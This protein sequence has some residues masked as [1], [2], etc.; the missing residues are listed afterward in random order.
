MACVHLAQPILQPS[1]ALPH[2]GSSFSL[3]SSPALGNNQILECNQH[4]LG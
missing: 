3:L 1:P 4:C 2:H